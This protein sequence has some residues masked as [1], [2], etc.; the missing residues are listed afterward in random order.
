MA[1][2]TLQ[3]GQSGEYGELVKLALPEGLALVFVPSLGALL[4]RAQQLSDA[5]LTEQQVLRIRDRS[6]VVAVHHD[7]ARRT[8]EQRGYVDID[9]ADAWRDWSR[10]QDG[11]VSA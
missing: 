3:A 6:N 5:P 10:L 2:S 9:A 1:M 4:T 7:V 8:E 11:D